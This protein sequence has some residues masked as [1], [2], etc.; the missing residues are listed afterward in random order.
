M[1]G[2]D[3]IEPQRDW[4]AG[5][6]LLSGDVQDLF[7]PVDCLLHQAARLDHEDVAPGAELIDNFTV[8]Q[9][10]DFLVGSDADNLQYL[11][12]IWQR[13]DGVE[14]CVFEPHRVSPEKLDLDGVRV[15]EECI[16]ARAQQVGDTTVLLHQRALVVGHIH[17][18]QHIP[19]RRVLQQDVQEG[20]LKLGLEGADDRHLD[21]PGFLEEGVCS[22][23]EYEQEASVTEDE[24]VLVICNFYDGERLAES[25][26]LNQRRK[27]RVLEFDGRRADDLDVGAALLQPL[28]QATVRARA[29]KVD[30]LAAPK[31]K[32]PFA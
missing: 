26:V 31:T 2:D 1:V 3:Q 20:M 7:A 8:L 10:Q 14:L 19:Q 18:G 15:L 4:I 23:T 5:H 29:Q 21:R 13:Q 32:A 17:Y 16:T 12:S 6:D 30:E 28:Q 25:G 11:R 27:L 9:E 22:R 24:P